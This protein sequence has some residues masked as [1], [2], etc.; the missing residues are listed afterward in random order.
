MR[1]GIANGLRFRHLRLAILAICLLFLLWKWEKGSLYSPD[2]IR[3]Q[4][5]ALSEL[6]RS[7]QIISSRTEILLSSSMWVTFWGSFSLK[8]YVANSMFA[9]QN[10]SM[11]EVSSSVDSF[12]RS[13]TEIAKEVTATPPPLTIVHSAQDATDKREISLP[14]KKGNAPSHTQYFARLFKIRRF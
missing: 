14:E 4:P 5:L 1:L 3:P 13:A 6:S 2:L 12:A 8:I 7:S 11:D 9:D 10:I